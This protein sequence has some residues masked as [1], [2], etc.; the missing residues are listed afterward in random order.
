MEIRECSSRIKSLEEYTIILIYAIT[1]KY[2]FDNGI[3]NKLHFHDL[4]AANEN[5]FLESFNQRLIMHE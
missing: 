2:Y 3:Y 5:M 4:G 1:K